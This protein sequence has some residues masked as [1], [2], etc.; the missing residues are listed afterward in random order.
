MWKA[1]SL[2]KQPGSKLAA[3]ALVIVAVGVAWHLYQHHLGQSPAATLANKRTFIC[4]VTGKTF[5]RKLE[6][7][8]TIPVRSPYSGRETGYEAEKCF[9]TREGT[10]KDEPTYVLLNE[11]RAEY[12]GKKAPPTFCP[13]CGRLVRSRNPAPEPGGR[14]PPTQAQY[15]ASTQREVDHDSR[16]KG[17]EGSR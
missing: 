12:R 2:I 16:I 11:H 1:R 10:A 8:M 4:A 7:G 15:N 13:D 17:K 5:T 14:P 6:A 9:W 3:G